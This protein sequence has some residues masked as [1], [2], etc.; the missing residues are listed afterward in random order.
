MMGWMELKWEADERAVSEWID[1]RI[2]DGM[3]RSWDLNAKLIE[4]AWWNGME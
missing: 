1:L 4:N 3:G 2:Y